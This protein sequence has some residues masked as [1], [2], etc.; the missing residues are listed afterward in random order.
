MKR[1]LL[2][3]DAKGWIFERHCNEIK[4]RITEYEFDIVF[5]WHSNPA[6][7]DYSK[8]DLVYQLDPMGIGGLNPPKEKTVMGLRN[9]FMYRHDTSGLISFYLSEIDRKC[10]MF[11]VVNRNQFKDFTPVTRIPLR[12]VPHGIDTDVFKPMNKKV[13]GAPLIVGTSG[14]PNS[15]GSKGWDI[16]VKACQATGCTL[17]TAAQNLQGGHLTKEQMAQYYNTIDIYCCMSQSEGLNNCI[18]EAGATAVPVITTRTGA[19]D[20][21]ISDGKNGFVVQRSVEALAD[22]LN[23]FKGQ[24]ERISEMGSALYETISSEWSWG[25]KISGFKEMFDAFFELKKV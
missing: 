23:F 12:L 15:A 7:Y 4:K 24:P 14:N 19:V 20:E 8:Y 10:C 1:I 3:A 25:K 18:M 21:Q 16:V 13:P 9:E 11:H 2:I 5:T 22:K 6:T 17:K